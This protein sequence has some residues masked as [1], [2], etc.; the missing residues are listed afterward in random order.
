MVTADALAGNCKLQIQKRNL[1]AWGECELLIDGATSTIGF[2][3]R[4]A[5]VS[6]SEHN[7]LCTAT[8]LRSVLALG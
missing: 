5:P 6:L 3:F 8:C 4:L 7:T 1:E 2:L